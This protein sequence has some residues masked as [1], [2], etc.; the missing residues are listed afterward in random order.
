MG[1]GKTNKMIGSNAEKNISTFFKELGFNLCEPS[2]FVEKKHDN[3]KIDLV[4]I[5]F[6]VQIKAGKQANMNPGK[7]LLSMQHCVD[8]MFT[9]G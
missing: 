8:L 3:A 4:N 9:K 1:I 7:E 2:R 5:P 6:N